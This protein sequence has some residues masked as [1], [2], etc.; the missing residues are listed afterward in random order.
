MPRT[1]IVDFETYY[2]KDYSLRKP[3]MSYPQF[4]RDKRFHVFG[5]SVDEDGEQYWV[6]ADAI[7]DWLASNRDNILV[8]HNGFFDF[9]VMAGTT[10]SSPPTWWI[11][12]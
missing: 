4:I 2:D 12:C 9:A 6:P 10:S 3:G 5:M 8:A 7:P 1:I 11:P